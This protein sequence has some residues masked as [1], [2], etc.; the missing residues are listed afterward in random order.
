MALKDLHLLTWITQL[1]LTVA[2]P[3]IGLILLAVW[4]RNRFSWGTWVLWIGVFLGLYCAIYGLYAS[5]KSLK[6][7]TADQKKEA[8]PVAFNDHI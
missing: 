6:R 2:V 5:L 3:P 8:P 4:L 1:G 7:F